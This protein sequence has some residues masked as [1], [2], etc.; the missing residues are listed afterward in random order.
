[1]QGALDSVHHLPGVEVRPALPDGCGDAGYVG[2]GVTRA[3]EA[4]LMSL[5]HEPIDEAR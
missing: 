1:V 3:L 5:R 2:R 4:L